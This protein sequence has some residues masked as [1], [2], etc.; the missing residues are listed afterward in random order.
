MAKLGDYAFCGRTWRKNMG[1]MEGAAGVKGRE[2]WGRA[3]DLRF[4]LPL[5]DFQL[6]L[7]C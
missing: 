5:I 1:E 4:L 7:R 2:I 3:R 6:S